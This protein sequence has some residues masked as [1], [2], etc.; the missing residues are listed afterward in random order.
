MDIIG[1]PEYL[2]TVSGLS[3]LT[4][5][6]ISLPDA[7]SYDKHLYCF[8]SLMGRLKARTGNEGSY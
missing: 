4:H 3:T 2:Y 7:T 8:P 5:G 1:F 6:V